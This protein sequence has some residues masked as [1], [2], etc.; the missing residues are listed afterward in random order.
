M[1]TIASYDNANFACT[2]RCI[3]PT[4][5]SASSVA[6]E[7]TT[8]DFNTCAASLDTST[9]DTLYPA[10]IQ[11]M[12]LPFVLLYFAGALIVFLLGYA[13]FM[14]YCALGVV[15]RF[16]QDAIRLMWELVSHMRT[17]KRGVVHGDFESS[18]DELRWEHFQRNQRAR[19]S[20]F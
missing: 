7:A 14:A 6:S 2:K 12:S 18:A 13:I 20:C 15:L 4:L 19:A 10:Y 9:L 5:S 17:F 16:A 3:A 11:C 8:E 1:H